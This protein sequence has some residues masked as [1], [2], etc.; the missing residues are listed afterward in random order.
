M[1]AMLN[2]VARRLLLVLLLVLATVLGP[3][4]ATFAEAGAVSGR[5]WAEN[6]CRS[7][8]GIYVGD[9]SRDGKRL[10]YPCD[11]SK[12]TSSIGWSDA[13]WIEIS[14]NT[15]CYRV[16]SYETASWGYILKGPATIGLGSDRKLVETHSAVNGICSKLSFSA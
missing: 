6:S 11:N 5:E 9:Y 14:S 16:Y 10:L 3:A 4:L 12:Y 13:D 15:I 8:R 7:E 1:Y 2:R